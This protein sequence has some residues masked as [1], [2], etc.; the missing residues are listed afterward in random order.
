MHRLLIL[1]S[2]IR[3]NKALTISVVALIAVVVVSLVQGARIGALE[4][5]AEEY[6]A[7]LAVNAEKVTNYD[8]IAKRNASLIDENSRIISE[9]VELN[10]L[11]NKIVAENETIVAE[12]EELT[13]ANSE[14][15]G[16]NGE[17]LKKFDGLSR[18]R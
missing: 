14:L 1:L 5:N 13:A 10:V 8:E 11:N 2:N 12:N 7:L 15:E 9:S 16:L 4:V 6:R 3:K 18:P 17:L